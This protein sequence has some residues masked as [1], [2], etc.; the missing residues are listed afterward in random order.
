MF[1]IGDQVQFRQW[2]W[3]GI[4]WELE[5]WTVIEVYKVD[6][7]YDDHTW[8]YVIENNETKEIR[9]E[10]SWIQLRHFEE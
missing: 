10:I 1:E 2:D 6:L 7:P 3:E 9:E 4:K 5:P 8:S